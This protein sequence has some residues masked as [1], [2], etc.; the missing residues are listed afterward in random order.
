MNGDL[1]GGLVEGP[2]ADACADADASSKDV[3]AENGHAPS[4]PSDVGAFDLL[5][6][7]PLKM[8]RKESDAEVP[9]DATDNLQASVNLLDH[10]TNN[11]MTTAPL[12]QTQR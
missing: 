3:P 10:T 6:G 7:S 4:P 5:S 1:L 12:R 9:L 8:E 2:N 11:N